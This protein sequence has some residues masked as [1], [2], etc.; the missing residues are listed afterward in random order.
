MV[1]ILSVQRPPI[2][3]WGRGHYVQSLFVY[4][5]DL[6]MEKELNVEM[7]FIQMMFV[8]IQVYVNHKSILISGTDR[9]LVAMIGEIIAACYI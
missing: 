3:R 2:G 4:S 6:N 7:T 9:R 5:V 1:Y 8:V